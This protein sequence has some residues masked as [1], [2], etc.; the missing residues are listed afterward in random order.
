[1]RTMAQVRIQI[2]KYGSLC[3]AAKGCVLLAAAAVVVVCCCCCCGHVAQ[4]A[5]VEQHARTVARGGKSAQSSTG[6][7][8]RRFHVCCSSRQLGAVLVSAAKEV[9]MCCA[10]CEGA[11]GSVRL[12]LGSMLGPLH[13][14]AKVRRVAQVRVSQTLKCFCLLKN[15]IVFHC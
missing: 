12:G 4:C 1:V 7:I 10:G 13:E 14:E 15:F 3:C 11:C 2:S 5:G 8:S 9:V 6:K